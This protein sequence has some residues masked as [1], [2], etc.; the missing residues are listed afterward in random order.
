MHGIHRYGGNQVVKLF[1]NHSRTVFFSNVSATLASAPPLPASCVNPH[2]Y[3]QKIAWWLWGVRF[4]RTAAPAPPVAC[5][6]FASNTLPLHVSTRRINLYRM[7]AVSIAP[8]R[9]QTV[10]EWFFVKKTCVDF[11]ILAM[12]TTA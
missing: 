1:V 12:Y 3:K 11:R 4:S 6:A 8:A 2:R 10:L 9:F 5:V 7:L